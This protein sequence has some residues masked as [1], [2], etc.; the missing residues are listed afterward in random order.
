MMLV[1][2]TSL[3]RPKEEVFG[4]GRWR[5]GRRGR[6]GGGLVSR[7]VDY[8]KM[9]RVPR[10]LCLGRHQQCRQKGVVGRPR[11]QGKVY[12]MTEQEVEDALDV[13]TEPL[14]ER[15]AVYTLVGDVLLVSEMLRNCEVLV[16][17]IDDLSGLPPDREIE[18]TIELFL[19]TT[20]IS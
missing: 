16:E 1:G 11:Q 13:I 6:G 3:L 5:F 4:M 14:S 10:V 20:P 17:C 7:P 9:D 12:A 2:F 18:F 8:H 19:G 15:L